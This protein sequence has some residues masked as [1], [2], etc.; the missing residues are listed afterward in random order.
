MST[1]TRPTAGGLAILRL[2]V[3]AETKHAGAVVDLAE[4]HATFA[5]LG[6]D[7]GDALASLVEED[8]VRIGTEHVTLTETGAAF[9]VRHHHSC[10][11]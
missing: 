7:P 10:H 11:R 2:F 8:L 5:R 6:R 9:F 4:V 3:R 1:T